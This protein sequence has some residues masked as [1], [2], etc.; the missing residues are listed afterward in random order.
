MALIRGISRAA[1][2]RARP[3]IGRFLL[4]SKLEERLIVDGS[5]CDLSDRRLCRIF[6]GEF[7]GLAVGLVVLNPVF[8]GAAPRAVA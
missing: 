1:H 7:C 8:R 2:S 6:L 3:P 5:L 4:L